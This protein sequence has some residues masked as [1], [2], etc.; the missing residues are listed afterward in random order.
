MGTLRR[1]GRTVEFVDFECI[2]RPIRLGERLGIV[3][4][5]FFARRRFA[6]ADV[7]LGPFPPRPVAA[8]GGVE[9]DL[10]ILEVGID[11]AIRSSLESRDGVGPFGGIGRPAQDIP[12]LLTAGEEPNLD[13]IPGPLHGVGSTFVEIEAVAEGAALGPAACVGVT[14]GAN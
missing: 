11:V 8:K 1:R 9:H 2:D 3:L 13:G 4:D 12:G 6:R 5:V 10:L 14:G 7:V